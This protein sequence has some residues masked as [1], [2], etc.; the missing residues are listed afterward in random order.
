M[1]KPSRILRLGVLAVATAAGFS[2]PRLAEASGAPYQLYQATDGSL[3]C[4]GRCL[5][6]GFVCCNIVPQ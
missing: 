5:G 4:G 1:I 3:I 6:A 2:L